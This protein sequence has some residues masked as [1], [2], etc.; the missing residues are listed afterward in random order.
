MVA[1]PDVLLVGGLDAAGRSVASVLRFDPGTGTLGAAGR[2]GVAVHDAAGGMIGGQVAVVGGGTAS[3][4]TAIVQSGPP[5]QTLRTT[6]ELP[7]RR[8]DHTAVVDGGRLLVVGGFD[9]AHTDL[10]VLATDDARNFGVIGHL[11]QG[12]RYAAAALVGTTL[13]VFGGEWAGRLTAAVQAVDLTTGKGR[14]VASL[15]APLA[16]S[17][18]LDLAGRIYLAGGRTPAG[19][20]SDVLRFDPAH[21]TFLPAGHLP[22]SESDAA[23]AVI[24]SV[25]YLFGGETPRTL[26][27]IVALRA[28]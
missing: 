16:H 17:A 27:T 8:S 13:Y 4:E 19:Y 6:G 14:V 28:A 11:A 26:A 9:G 21:L 22:H 10:D 7:R 12:V 2:L 3:G 25:G 1:G 5:D 20:S 23:A 24:G 15:P 18:A